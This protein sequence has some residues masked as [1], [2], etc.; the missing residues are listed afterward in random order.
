MWQTKISIPLSEIQVTHHDKMLS[1]G[2]CFADEIGRRLQQLH[3]NIQV[4]PFGIIYNPISLS[5]NIGLISGRMAWNENACFVHQDLWRHFDFHSRIGKKDRNEYITHVQDKIEVSNQQ[6][7]L[8]KAVILTFGSSFVWEHVDHGIVGNCHKLPSADFKRR[9]LSLD[10]I[11]TALMS[12]KKDVNAVNPFCQCIVT[13]SP[14][15]HLRDGL[16]Q[17]TWS[18]S[19]LLEACRS[20]EQAHEDV[21]YF[22]SYEIMMDELRDYRFY[23]DDMVH[24]SEPAINYIFSRFLETYGE[25]VPDELIRLIKKIN[26][27]YNHRPSDLNSEAYVRHNKK[28]KELIALVQKQYGIFIEEV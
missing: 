19:R 12:I 21:V 3:F 10:E 15:R 11:H 27:N 1:L 20:F 5:K 22:P 9:M 7:K 26:A 18:K 8:A 14:V 17:N 25:S 16:I 28:T 13:V 2:S 6:L 23:K 24:P 4:N